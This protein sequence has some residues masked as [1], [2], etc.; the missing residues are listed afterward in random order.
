MDFLIEVIGELFFEGVF[1]L[2][3]NKKISKFVRYPALVLISI[4]Y[5]LL[6]LLFIY[7]GL[8]LQNLWSLFFFLVGI[9]LLVGFIISLRKRV[10][11]NNNEK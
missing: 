2:A 5:L 10:K 3:T 6:F 1:E 11:E 7:I 8:N 4:I 9:L